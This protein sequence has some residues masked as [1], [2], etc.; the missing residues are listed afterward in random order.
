MNNIISDLNELKKVSN[1][2]DPGTDTNELIKELLTIL[3]R[4]TAGICL[5]A[6]QIGIPLRIGVISCEGVIKHLINPVIKE[7][8]Y[9]ALYT[10]ASLSFPNILLPTKRYA[11]ILLSADNLES[12]WVGIDDEDKDKVNVATRGFMSAV[13]IQQL[14]D[15]MDGITIFDRLYKNEPVIKG[16]EP[17]RNDYV[18]IINEES[19]KTLVLKYK[20]IQNYLKQGWKLV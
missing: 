10:E 5:A 8:K 17:E 15:H 1:H 12:T 6:C 7:F 13:A 9:P 3:G 20:K 11:K 14:V 19:G 18:T 4:N 2:V 16:K